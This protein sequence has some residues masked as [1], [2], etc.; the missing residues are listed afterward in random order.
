M[1][2]FQ[3][4]IFFIRKKYVRAETLENNQDEGT[5]RNGGVVI[6]HPLELNWLIVDPFER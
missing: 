6:L 2:G 4:L 5:G 3:N 1:L